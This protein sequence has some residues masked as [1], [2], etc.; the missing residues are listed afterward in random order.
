MKR[1]LVGAGGMILVVALA[2]IGAWYVIHTRS[3]MAEETQ[4][5]EDYRVKSQ[6]VAVT[7]T[8][9]VP[10]NTPADQVLYLSGSV[11]A[12]GNWDAAGVP[13]AR[14]PDGTYRATVPDLLNSM[15]YAFKVTR[16]TWGSV[17]TDAGGKEIPNHT[18]TAGR[19]GA[20]NVAVANWV[21]TGQSVPGRVTM[22][23]DVRLHKKFHSN[24]LNNDRTLIVYLPPDYE[25][26][27]SARFPVLYLQDGQNLF[28]E[29]TSYQGIEWKLDEAAQELNGQHKI[30]PAI[31]VGVYNTPARDAEYT[32]P[33][34]GAPKD[35]A[36]GDLYARMLVEEI[37]PF[38]D[39]TYRTQPGRETTLV[40]GGSL[41][42]LVALYAAKAHHDVFGHVVAL[43]PWLRLG[44]KPIVTEL[45]GDGAWLKDTKLF[46][47][48]GTAPGHNYPGG[49]ASAANAVAD[50]QAL[51]AVLTK[52]GLEPG[53]QFQYVEIEGGRHNEQSWQAIVPQM[54]LAVFGVP[55]SPATGPT[56]TTSAMP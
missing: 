40:G 48:M 18:F 9:R 47:E 42:G 10:P 28:D 53:R 25:K 36:K 50:A 1:R 51:V 12:L 29:A 17:E 39:K 23:G 7:F 56:T 32:P 8:V 46:V 2:A 35:G 13:L 5:L 52:A 4:A 37:K 49:E 3:S 44:D 30:R 33:L 27:K 6:P 55:A 11:P 24:L 20:V 16:G 26:D 31:L 45:V 21:D 41:G 34:A 22:T 43:S 19:D 15:D 38:I 14:Q 54:L